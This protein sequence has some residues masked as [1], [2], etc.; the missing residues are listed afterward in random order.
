MLPLQ[1]FAVSQALSIPLQQF[2]ATAN[3]ET[4]IGVSATHQ[5]FRHP[6]R[7]GLSWGTPFHSAVMLC[8][9]K[10]VQ[11]LDK[12]AVQVWGL[13]HN[14]ERKTFAKPAAAMAD[15]TLS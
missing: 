7:D 15:K 3:V 1:G 11:H 10:Q 9:T 2:R 6:F 14:L 13:M 5:I 4:N 8:S 12:K